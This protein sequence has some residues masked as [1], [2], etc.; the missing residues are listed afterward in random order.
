MKGK[1]EGSRKG[2]KKLSR[3]HKLLTKSMTFAEELKQ[4]RV[5]NFPTGRILKFLFVC[6]VL[7]YLF[8]CKA[9]FW[10]KQF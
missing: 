2:R 5:K 10:G 1:S 3:Y 8:I 7:G 9:L 4:F 6:F